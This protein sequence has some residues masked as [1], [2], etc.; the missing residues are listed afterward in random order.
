MKNITLS[1]QNE[2]GKSIPRKDFFLLWVKTA[3]KKEK[4]KIT[5][6]FVKEGE[7][8]TLNAQFRNK[9]A[10]TNILSFPYL[11]TRKK[12]EGDLLLCPF[13]IEKEAQE[14]GKS[15]F[16]HYAH[17]IIHGVLHLKG[18]DHENEADAQIMEALEIHFLKQLGINNPYFPRS[19]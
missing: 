1:L 8:Q 5:L 12:L 7:S 16:A 10:P 2:S 3:L 19:T 9:N 13:V 17:L 14:Q 4:A 18:L 6:R 11:C 15:L